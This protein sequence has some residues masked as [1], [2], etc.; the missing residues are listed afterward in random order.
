[1]RIGLNGY[2]SFEVA[3]YID[4]T[5]PVGTDLNRINMVTH[6]STRRRVHEPAA[7]VFDNKDHR[8]EM[9]IKK[10]TEETARQLG[11]FD[12]CSKATFEAHLLPF[13]ESKWVPSDRDIDTFGIM[14]T[15]EP[16]EYLMTIPLRKACNKLPNVGSAV[17]VD[18]AVD[19]IFHTAPNFLLGVES[20]KSLYKISMVT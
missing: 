16:T 3:Q 11:H 18:L 4:C 10:A 20:L 5:F 15:N 14:G 6:N 9:L 12:R 17:E 13:P 7:N 2:S 19:Q 1:L 8:T